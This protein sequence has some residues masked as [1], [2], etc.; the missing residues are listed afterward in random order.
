VAKPRDTDRHRTPRRF[1]G[2]PDDLWVAFA[3]VVGR[4]G[5]S[6]DLRRYVAWRIRHPHTPLPDDKP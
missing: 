1:I 6:A 3:R 5:R 2:M 4:N